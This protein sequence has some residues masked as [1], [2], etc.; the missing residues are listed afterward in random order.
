MICLAPLPQASVLHCK[1]D[2]FECTTEQILGAEFV[3]VLLQRRQR[4][5]TAVAGR[6]NSQVSYRCTSMDDLQDRMI[7]QVQRGY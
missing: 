7:N 4:W 1:A 5:L 3:P 2:R 6:L